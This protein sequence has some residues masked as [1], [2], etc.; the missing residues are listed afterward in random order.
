MKW[1][2]GSSPDYDAGAAEPGSPDIPGCRCQATPSPGL[3]LSCQM[4]KETMPLNGRKCWLS[5]GS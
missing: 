1:K 4:R 5:G 2:A 3:F